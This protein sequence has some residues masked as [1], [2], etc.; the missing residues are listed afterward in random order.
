MILLIV[1]ICYV[2]I[3][4]DATTLTYAKA[5]KSPSPCPFTDCVDTSQ[6]TSLGLPSVICICRRAYQDENGTSWKQ[7]YEACSDGFQPLSLSPQE[8]GTK[9]S[10]PNYEFEALPDDQF[11]SNLS[12]SIKPSV[13]RLYQSTNGFFITFQTY[14]FQIDLETVA[15][16]SMIA[17]QG[18]RNFAVSA[19]LTSFYIDYGNDLTNLARFQ[20]NNIS[21]L[22]RV[23]PDV[24]NNDVTFNFFGSSGIEAKIIR[25]IPFNQNAKYLR[26][27]LYGKK[28]LNECSV[29]DFNSCDKQ[30]AICTDTIAG[31]NCTCNQGS[32]G[33]STA[34]KCN[35]IN[36][37]TTT[38]AIYKNKCSF[39]ATCMDTQF[40][41]NCTC[42]KGFQGDGFYCEDIN[43]C[44]LSIPPT[45]PTCD[46]VKGYCVNTIGSHKCFC[47]TGYSGDGTKCVD[48]NE[49]RKGMAKC[50]INAECSN[51]DGSYVC[52]CNGGYSGN[53]FQCE[54]IDEC[55]N[56]PCSPYAN[57]TDLKPFYECK[58]NKGFSGNGITCTD[59][60]EC[61]E[62][63]TCREN[64]KCMNT[65][66][67]YLCICPNVMPLQKPFNEDYYD[68]KVLGFLLN[69]LKDDTEGNYQF[70][71][72]YHAQKIR[73]LYYFLEKTYEF[74]SSKVKESFFMSQT[75]GSYFSVELYT[76][77]CTD[78]ANVSFPNF[79]HSSYG[80][81]FFSFLT[82]IVNIR[83]I[84]SVITPQESYVTPTPY[85]L[86]KDFV[87]NLP[88]TTNASSVSNDTTITNVVPPF[89]CKNDPIVGSLTTSE[90][91]FKSPIINETNKYP[92]NAKCIWTIVVPEPFN[93][94][95]K[96]DHFDLEVSK[97]CIYDYV[98]VMDENGNQLQKYCGNNKTNY[99]LPVSSGSKIIV[100]FFSDRE[101]E[102]TGF[103]A[104]WGLLYPRVTLACIIYNQ[105]ASLP[106]SM[107]ENWKNNLKL[108]PKNEFVP[109]SKLIACNQYPKCNLSRPG[110]I[111]YT[112]QH[113]RDDR[114]EKKCIF[115]SL[116]STA[117]TYS[118]NVC[119]K[120]KTNKTH[121]ICEC[122]T[123]GIVSVLGRAKVYRQ[124]FQFGIY[125]IRIN[126]F[127]S[128][129]FVTLSLVVA[130]VY[131]FL[132][133]QWGAT[134]LEAIRM[135]EFDSGRV[136]NL[137]IMVNTLMTEI[138]FLI[139]TFNVTDESI[140]CYI[141]VFLFYYFLQAVFFWL[142]IYTLFLQSRV[143]EIFDSEKYNSYKIYLF[144]GYF[145]P[146]LVTLTISGL[147][148]EA[149][150]KELCWSLFE[151]TSVWGFSSVIIT[152]AIVTLLMLL[153]V[154]RES[155][156]L[157][158]GIILQEKCMKT[159]FT[160]FFMLLTAIFGVVGIQT[161]LFSWQYLFSLCNL[162]QGF[163]IVIL[164]CILRREDPIIKANQIGPI[165]EK[166]E[167]DDGDDIEET[168]DGKVFLDISPYES[169]V[170]DVDDVKENVP[171][172]QK[173]F[174][175]RKKI[176]VVIE[177]NEKE[178][179]YDAALDEQDKNDLLSDE[180]QEIEFRNENEEDFFVR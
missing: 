132:K 75:V 107:V 172:E 170:E 67:S 12:T 76:F 69:N 123:W 155:K 64:E 119:K 53:G 94:Y 148:F 154:F 173:E 152:I 138:V 139:I 168:E 153:D 140:S 134:A 180:D 158:N 116:Y 29:S 44:A 32:L 28:T 149:Y 178:I 86:T 1:F 22:F 57:C 41:Y 179:I 108:D 30:N 19:I 144:V 97:S 111:L 66:G 4:I 93:L 90:G 100:E 102:Y 49:C 51:T 141:L 74:H 78:V 145:V 124:K 55:L 156:T 135:K 83:L 117:T 79:C 13:A 160:T 27:E 164:Y 115:W 24:K 133:D 62:K 3:Y 65:Q 151:G 77:R 38:D 47:K 147:N 42:K 52:T 174:P 6:L 163:S 96:F 36:E 63:D 143:Q 165:P 110:P 175:L 92:P 56:F 89:I 99:L 104:K 112:F 103:T 33:T 159:G 109:V 121:T 84:E 122:Q 54:N 80:N 98:A 101:D 40:A 87:N 113:F 82:D 105:L 50:D 68:R 15:F 177:S 48:I 95:V 25:V 127:Y 31:Y 45:N 26:L 131:L 11:Q 128:S 88:D 46:S 120:I 106:D 34:F 58:C 157:P 125:S 142:Y 70:S 23:P 161:E 39:N 81:S 37:C 73:T 43:E 59:K 2:V 166:I 129:L 146:L 16:V 114:V 176:I 7:G 167:D 10:T 60:N 17:T 9:I 85:I 162:L 35:L 72:D 18:P 150:S 169:E 91:Y 5:C 71:L 136:I 61:D 137:H 126:C 118:E 8:N 20:F 171:S 14:Y 130:T 21:F